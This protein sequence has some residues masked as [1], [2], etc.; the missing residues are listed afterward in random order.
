MFRTCS[1]HDSLYR[2]VAVTVL[3]QWRRLYGW[4]WY[5][6]RFYSLH[7]IILLSHGLCFVAEGQFAIEQFLTM[8]CND[9]PTLDRMDSLLCFN[10]LVNLDYVGSHFLLALCSSQT[11]GTSKKV[12][13]AACSR[14][15]FEVRQTLLTITEACSPIRV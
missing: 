15:F 9:Q 10:A 12:S 1:L 2:I 7:L 8:T 6:W 4:A 14:I 5:Y 3:T 13:I 11:L